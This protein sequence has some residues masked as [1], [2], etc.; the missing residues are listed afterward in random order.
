MREER[1]CMRQRG[2]VSGW[3]KGVHGVSERGGVASHAL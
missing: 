1:E 2:G 3:V